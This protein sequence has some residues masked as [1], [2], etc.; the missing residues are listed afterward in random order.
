M[1]KTLLVSYEA[2]PGEDPTMAAL[3][4]QELLE[5]M[6][7]PVLGVLPHEPVPIDP[8]PFQMMSVAKA[9]AAPEVAP[10]QI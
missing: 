8:T 9:T 4:V 2:T 10:P 1:T 7:F 3:Q 6:D 5:S